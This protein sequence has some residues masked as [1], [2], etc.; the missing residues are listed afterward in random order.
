MCFGM[1][2]KKIQLLRSVE[3]KSVW[4]DQVVAVGN[5]TELQDSFSRYNIKFCILNRR[6]KAVVGVQF[7]YPGHWFLPLAAPISLCSTL[8]HSVACVRFSHLL[9]KDPTLKTFYNSLFSK[10]IVIENKTESRTK[11]IAETINWYYYYPR[12]VVIFL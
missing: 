2:L 10:T 1:N 7:D 4:Q 5:L 6:K 9:W 11:L 12:M 3:R 8:L